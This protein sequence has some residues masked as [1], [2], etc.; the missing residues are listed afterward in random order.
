MQVRKIYSPSYLAW[1]LKIDLRGLSKIIA[2]FDLERSTLVI[3]NFFISCSQSPHDSKR[4]IQFQNALRYTDFIQIRLWYTADPSA[5]LGH[6]LHPA[7]RVLNFGKR[8]KSQGVRPIELGCGKI[9]TFVFCKTL[10]IIADIGL[11]HY[12]RKHLMLRRLWKYYFNFFDVTS[13]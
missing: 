5:C 7:R 1:R 8:K 3:T 4:W 11:G 6:Y 13:L 2:Y 10:E 9:V 12:N